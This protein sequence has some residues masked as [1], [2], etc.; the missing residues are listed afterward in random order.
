MWK[1]LLNLLL[2]METFI[3]VIDYVIYLIDSLLFLWNFDFMS[4]L[5]VFILAWMLEDVFP[6]LS[7]FFLLDSIIYVGYPSN[8][9][10][11][12]F[13]QDYVYVTIMIFFSPISI[14]IPVFLGGA[15]AL[16]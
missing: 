15:G 14:F 6:F 8:L 12:F 13:F 7:P 5:Y 1:L 16:F 11:T 9:N 10:C 4:M 2:G 3:F